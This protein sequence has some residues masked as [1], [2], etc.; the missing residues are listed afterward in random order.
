[1]QALIAA[2]EP[3]YIDNDKLL[4]IGTDGRGREL[5]I[6]GIIAAEDEELVIVIYV[7][8]TA[9]RKDGHWT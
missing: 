7:M 5:E 3:T 4:W 1:M 8:P 9:F 6:I 2:G